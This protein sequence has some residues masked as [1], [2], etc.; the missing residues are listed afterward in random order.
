MV[1]EC[2][3][4]SVKVWVNGDLVNHGFDCTAN[5]GQIALQAEGSEVEFRKVELTPIKTLTDAG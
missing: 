5:K 1:I 4:T 2:L 3:G